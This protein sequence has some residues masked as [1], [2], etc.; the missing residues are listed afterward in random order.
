MNSYVVLTGFILTYLIYGVS[1]SQCSLQVVP[2]MISTFNSS[3]LY[4]YKGVFNVRSN[5]TDG[6]SN[7]EEI[8]EVAKSSD[9]D[10]LI[11]TDTETPEDDSSFSGYSGRLIVFDAIETKYLDSRLVLISKKK[12][13]E[14]P[15]GSIERNLYLTDLLSQKSFNNNNE[16]AVLLQP[17]QTIK[18]FPSPLPT[19]LGGLEILNSKTTSTTAWSDSKL[20][21]LWSVIS[22]P[23]NVQ[24]SFSRLFQA[25]EPDL[26]IF[27]KTASFRKIYMWAGLDATAR[28]LPLANYLIEFPSYE[29]SFGLMSNRVLLNSELTGSFE[30]D[31]GK[32]LEALSQG[33]FYLSIDSL[34]DPK[35]FNFLAKVN[36]QQWLMGSTVESQK[37]LV[38]EVNLPRTPNY[39]FEIVLYKDGQQIVASNKNSISFPVNEK[40]TYRVMVR[41]AVPFPLPDGIKWVPW[42]YS[43]PIWVDSVG[44]SQ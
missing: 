8:I 11:L 24:Y 5:R 19:G 10:F 14:L 29:K 32:L 3:K 23:F 17:Q 26:E 1:L 31:S 39:F 7:P 25:P 38:L 40:G 36:S 41:V 22:Y 9:L 13:V 44:E 37:D 35:G 4:E 12:R 21:V 16:I 28:A 33:N 20:K 2:S 30:K 43:N 34:G 42:I 15:G 6:Y 27:D 18:N